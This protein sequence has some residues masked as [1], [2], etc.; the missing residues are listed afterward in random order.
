MQIAAGRVAGGRPFVPHHRFVDLRP[1]DIAPQDGA[2][3]AILHHELVPVIEEPG[4]S[5]RPG[6]LA[7]PPTRIVAKD[8]PLRARG[9]PHPDLKL[10][11]GLSRSLRGAVTVDTIS[12][13]R[14][15][16]R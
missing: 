11:G 15:H 9:P 14:R 1:M 4:R 7:E 8:R 6:H 12:E 13:T 3:A 2:R 10:L 5:R 16:S